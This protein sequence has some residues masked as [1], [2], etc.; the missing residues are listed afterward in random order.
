MALF[1]RHRRA[2]YIASETSHRLGAEEQREGDL[3]ETQQ[4]KDELPITMRQLLEAGGHFGHQT[5]RWN[6]KMRP[7]IFRAPNATHNIH[8]Q[9]TV[10]LINRSFKFIP[11]TEAGGADL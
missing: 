11:D 5:K 2:I 4:Q 6:P 8:L 7:F 10:K 9:H 1:K 3:M